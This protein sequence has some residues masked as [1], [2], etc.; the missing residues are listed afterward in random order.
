MASLASIFG[1]VYFLFSPLKTPK[2]SYFLST[3]NSVICFILL[4]F[5][6]YIPTLAQAALL[7]IYTVAGCS[8]S[9]NYVPY[10]IVNQYFNG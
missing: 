8:R 10:L 5:I 9:F 3:I 7:L 4:P 6:T 2:K 1:L